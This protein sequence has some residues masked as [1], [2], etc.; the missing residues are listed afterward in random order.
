MGEP[1]P[2]LEYRMVRQTRH[3]RHVIVV[4][5]R[6]EVRGENAALRKSLMPRPELLS[7]PNVLSGQGQDYRA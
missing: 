4:K 1:Y 3:A 6:R 5:G 2:R 7:G